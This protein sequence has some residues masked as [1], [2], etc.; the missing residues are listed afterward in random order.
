[1]QALRHF[2]QRLGLAVFPFRVWLLGAGV[3]SGA[4]GVL[5]L[6]ADAG[7]SQ[8]Y[9]L[10]SLVLSLWFLFFLSL[11]YYASAASTPPRPRAWLQALSWSLRNAWACFLAII[12]LLVTLAL[13]Y[14]SLVAFR[15][16]FAS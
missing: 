13:L 5:L 12:C 6:F 14:M 8:R 15:I 4:L 11:A 1:M 2:Y 16:A 10:P 9:L 7:L 3:S